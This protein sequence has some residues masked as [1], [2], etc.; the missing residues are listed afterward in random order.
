MT[1]FLFRK[2][3]A[4]TVLPWAWLLRALLYIAQSVSYNLEAS[5]SYC[6]E[7]SDSAYCYALELLREGY[8]ETT[9]AQADEI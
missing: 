7:V 5:F 3:F 2:Y 8:K 9:E 4:L 1:A 6:M